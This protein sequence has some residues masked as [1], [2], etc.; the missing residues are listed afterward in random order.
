M[1]NLDINLN[2]PI[3]ADG[4]VLYC[5]GSCR[6][7]P[8][9]IG[10]GIHGFAYN[11]TTSKKSS[12]NTSHK[13]TSSGYIINVD[14]SKLKLT[15]VT[16]LMYYNVIGSFNFTAT[17]N[18]AE[19]LACHIGIKLAL[20]T[21][22]KKLLI[23]TDSDYVVKVLTKF[24]Q[25]WVKTNWKK[26][27]GT[28]VS[29]KEL[30]KDILVSLDELHNRQIEFDLQ[31]VKGHSTH[32]GNNTAD[33][34][35]VIG[36]E[37]SRKN[38]IT[39]NVQEHIA[40][41]YWKIDNDRH[42]FLSH[43]RVYFS[44]Q[45]DN[46]EGFY[47]IGNHGKEDDF[48]GRPQVDTALAVLYLKEKQ[49]V[50]DIIIDYCKKLSKTAIRFFFIR[51]DAVY[52]KNRNKDIEKFKEN[53]LYVDPKSKKINV[54]TNESSKND[55]NDNTEI[56]RDLQPVRLSERTFNCLADLKARLVNY[57]NNN[58]QANEELTDITDIFYEKKIDKKDVTTTV[59]QK[60]FVVGYKSEKIKVKSKVKD[61]DIILTL[62]LDIADRNTLKRLEDFNPTI[63][64]LTWMESDVCMRYASIIQTAN[65]YSI[66]CSPY[67][68]QIYIQ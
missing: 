16:P 28:E 47:Y 50:L 58:I 27:D 40:D 29:N 6:P 35:A 57:I 37:M 65:D 5:D 22:V 31:W 25:I 66:W 1:S 48:V 26:R 24:A 62:S 20:A 53:Y 49:P 64:I 68:N 19:L 15:E 30:I 11:D 32:L 43:P 9:F 36:S 63:K 41:G 2:T 4:L 34:L 52:S 67:S 13:L 61:V 42:P 7:N 45:E 14:F 21:K 51:L 59:L 44:S 12:G 46:D 56:V 38:I 17:N 54:K 3:V 55:S 39:I 33:K 10:A 18:A 8:G 60:K 23:K